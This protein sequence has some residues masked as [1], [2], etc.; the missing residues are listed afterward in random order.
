MNEQ[1]WSVR[2]KRTRGAKFQRC[3]LSL[4]L[5]VVVGTGLALA[6][7]LGQDRS[8]IVRAASGQSLLHVQGTQLLDGNNRPVVLRGAMIES[9]FAYLKQWQGGRDPLKILNTT[10]FT[11]MSQQWHMNAVRLDIS[12]WI[13]QLD[14]GTYMS[15]LDQA[16]A[17]A[18]AADLYVI[19]DFHDTAQSGAVAPYTD[20]MMHRVSLDWWKML[21]TH[22][23]HN[24]MIIYD[25][26]NE[27]KYTSWATWLHGDGADI[28]GYADAIAA[29]RSTGSQQIIV[30]EPGRAGGRT[31]SEKG[32]A[33]FDPAMITDPN[34]LYSRHIYHQIISGN[35]TI[36]DHAWGPLLNTR[37]IYYGEWA[38][39]PHP[40][41]ITHCTGLTSTNADALTKAFLAYLDQRHANWTAWDFR[42]SHL[43]QNTRDFTPTTF[44]AAAS[45]NC[46]GASGKHA[47]MGTAVL[48]YLNSIT[49]S[50]S[51]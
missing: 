40:D 32:W 15:R 47:G 7:C 46:G 38:V 28:V 2:V 5:T 34:I 29:I 22:Y 16:I 9:P 17:Q 43:I 37:P 20:G 35:P 10:T 23:L 39:L 36:W 25:V 50:S 41:K 1:K 31:A 45:W 3:L 49:S 21:A 6:L 11:A 27:P 8:S 24:P 44:A 14:P 19:L 26:L 4:M 51:A 48:Q 12:Q 13:Y 30:V 33:T 42:P 18:N